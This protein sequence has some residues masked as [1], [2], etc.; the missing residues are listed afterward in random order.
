[1]TGLMYIHVSVETHCYPLHALRISI[2]ISNTYISHKRSQNA[3]YCLHNL[4]LLIIVEIKQF[5]QVLSH[6]RVSRLSLFRT[7][8]CAIITLGTMVNL[9]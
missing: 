4:D 5:V 8:Y 6:L 9:Q 1:M 2:D 7:Q 3:I